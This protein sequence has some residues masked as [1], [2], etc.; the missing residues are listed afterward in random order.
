MEK[1][2]WDEKRQ[3]ETNTLHPPISSRSPN[4]NEMNGYTVWY[5]KERTHDGEVQMDF[6]KVFDTTWPT[7]NKAYGRSRALSILLEE[8]LENARP[9]GRQE[10]WVLLLSRGS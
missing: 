5:S 10:Q 1:I 2:K 6:I 8:F 9:I 4:G 3:F 7:K